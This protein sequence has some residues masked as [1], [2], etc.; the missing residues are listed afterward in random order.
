ML[1]LT[2]L[3][4]VASFFSQNFTD[5]SVNMTHFS[6]WVTCPCYSYCVYSGIWTKLVVG[7][8]TILFLYS[9]LAFNPM[10]MGASFWWWVIRDLSLPNSFFLIFPRPLVILLTGEFTLHLPVLL[11]RC[12]APGLWIFGSFSCLY[13][14]QLHSQECPLLCING[15]SA[16]LFS[17]VALYPY[18]H[19]EGFI[20][21]FGKLCKI[22]LLFSLGLF[23]L[24]LCH[25]KDRSSH[26]GFW[27]MRCGKYEPKVH[28]SAWTASLWALSP[29]LTR[30]TFYLV[31]STIYL[32]VCGG[33][34]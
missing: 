11:S 25:L 9:F 23:F 29:F 13:L 3:S 18:G 33:G 8:V 17:G 6:V 34:T 21:G 4:Q 32:F 15:N 31:V 7:D 30:E 14:L 10:L 19:F 26:L 2:S 24:I 5:T 28:E 27:G 16:F 22:Q 1:K 20:R 12:W